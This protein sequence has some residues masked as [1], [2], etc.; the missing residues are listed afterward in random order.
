MFKIKF[1]PLQSLNLKMLISG[2]QQYKSEIKIFQFDHS[3]RIFF[4]IDH[5]V[6]TVEKFF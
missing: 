2:L 6:T 1:I 4:Y 3:T 5:K